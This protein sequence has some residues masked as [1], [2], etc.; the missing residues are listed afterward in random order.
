MIMNSKIDNLDGEPSKIFILNLILVY[1][2][3]S[4]TLLTPPMM[5]IGEVPEPYP[6]ANSGFADDQVCPMPDK[7]VLQSVSFAALGHPFFHNSDGLPG[8]VTSK[9]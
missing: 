7:P 8:V 3:L 4:M 1:F 2:A 6:L 5:T 9:A